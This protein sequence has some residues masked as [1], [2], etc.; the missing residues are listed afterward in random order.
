MQLVERTRLSVAAGQWFQQLPAS[1]LLERGQSLIDDEL[2]HCLGYNLL[3]WGVVTPLTLPAGLRE[4]VRLGVPG[5]EAELLCS[6]ADWPVRQHA[7]DV[8]VLQHALEFADSPHR[9][10]H[11][12]AR[13]VRPGGHLLIL[14]IQPWSLWGLRRLWCRDVQRDSHLL[15]AARVTDWLHLLG[16]AVENRRAGCYCPPLSSP[17]LCARLERL[18]TAPADLQLPGAGLYLLRA[19]KL[20]VGLRPLPERSRGLVVPLPVVPLGNVGRESG[21]SGPQSRQ[22]KP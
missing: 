10:L 16:F 3:H 7:A 21:Q 15:T 19:R 5:S 2:A 8:V 13:C 4:L 1:L 9:L 12:A 6:E 20:M 11:E 17:R 22:D 14:T 18:A